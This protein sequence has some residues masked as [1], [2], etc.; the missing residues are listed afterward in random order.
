MQRP[1][2][3]TFLVEGEN[4]TVAHSHHSTQHGKVA[5]ISRTDADWDTLCKLLSDYQSTA[6]RIGELE[7]RFR[8]V[9]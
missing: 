2:D 8:D 7:P 6:Q 1:K 9:G 5:H 3:L 4:I